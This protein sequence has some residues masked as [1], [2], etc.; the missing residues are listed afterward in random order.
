M[1]KRILWLVA[2]IALATSVSAQRNPFK[3][4]T[5]T[6]VVTQTMGDSVV[7]FHVQLGGDTDIE[8][9]PDRR[10]HWFHQGRLHQSVGGFA[11][12]LLNGSF[13]R[14]DRTGALREK[15]EFRQGL[16]I[17]VWQVWH[18]NGN[19]AGRYQWR[20]GARQ[21]HF[22]EYSLQG[23]LLQEGRYKADALHG[24][25]R[26]YTADGSVEKLRYRH[27]QI[28]VKKE[29]VKKEDQAVVSTSARVDNNSS[30]QHPRWWTRLRNKFKRKPKDP[31]ISTTSPEDQS[32]KGKRQPRKKKHDAQQNP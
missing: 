10:Y 31:A 3:G 8:T 15:G 19:L 14:F 1:D 21:G 11:G 4:L 28:R 25:V 9:I 22:E 16:K 2:G 5:P 7:N 18:G 12:K 20:R 24:A 26:V 29:K 13:E 23:R 27:G 6:N 32:N 30:D 17:G